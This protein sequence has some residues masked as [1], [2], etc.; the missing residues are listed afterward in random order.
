M[1]VGLMKPN[2]KWLDVMNIM[3]CGPQDMKSL[4]LFAFLLTQVSGM[5]YEVD[6]EPADGWWEYGC[7]I[8]GNYSSRESL[9][10]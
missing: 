10:M 6:W 5:S 4:L 9:Y 1:S 3:N 8:H 2:V 7:D